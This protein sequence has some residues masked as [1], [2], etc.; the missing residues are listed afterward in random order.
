VEV[1]D[2]QY[3]DQEP[4]IETRKIIQSINEELFIDDLSIERNRLLILMFNFVL[5][6]FEFP[7]WLNKTSLIDV[8]HI[9]RE[10]VPYQIYRPDNQE[11]VYD[12]LQEVKHITYKSKSFIWLIKV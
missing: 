12:Y 4:V 9:I 10:L 7:D 11:F 6:E 5:T 8:K 1:F 2:A 3:F